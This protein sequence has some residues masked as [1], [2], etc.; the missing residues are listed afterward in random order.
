MSPNNPI[1]SI[2]RQKQDMKSLSMACR[3]RKSLMTAMRSAVTA[4]LSRSSRI[5]SINTVFAVSQSNAE[6]ATP[7]SETAISCIVSMRPLNINE[8]V[9][10]RSLRLKS[11]GM[12]RYLSAGIGVGNNGLFI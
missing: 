3:D 10:I 6:I 8:R 5:P 9:R 11:T 4:S 12:R 2:V 1:E 7:S